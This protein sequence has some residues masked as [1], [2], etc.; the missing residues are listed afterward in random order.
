MKVILTESLDNLGAAG[1]V[2]DVADGYARNYLLPNKLAL[3]ADEQNLKSLEFQKKAIASRNAKMM[4]TMQ[5]VA[6]RLN[7]HACKIAKKTGEEN[8]LFGS[9]TN[10]DIADSLQKAGFSVDK[11]Q[12]VLADP[13]KA[14]GTYEVVV[15]LNPTVSANI[16]VEVVAE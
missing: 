4:K 9:V 6:N 5:D 13:I 3:M 15:K 7:A 11:K 1:T 2:C 16:K 14:L 12:V 10:G 8:R